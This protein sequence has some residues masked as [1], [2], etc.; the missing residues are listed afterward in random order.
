MMRDSPRGADSAGN[1]ERIGKASVFQTA[2]EIGDQ[3]ML[4]AVKMCAATDV[5]QQA[6]GCIAGYQ[7]CVTQAPVG[8]G[9]I[10]TAS[11]SM[12]SGAASISGCMARACANVRPGKRPSRSA[13]SS[14]AVRTSTLLRLPATTSGADCSRDFSRNLAMRSVE[15]WR[16]HRLSKRCE[17]ELSIAVTPFENP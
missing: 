15:S 7:W 14:T 6:I 8:N 4:A 1:G 16:S 10:R 9:L 5:Q 13:A 2:A 17:D 3:F 12:S 11:A